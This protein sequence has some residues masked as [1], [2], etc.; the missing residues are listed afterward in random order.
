MYGYSAVGC[1]NTYT[2][3]AL[4]NTAR[5]PAAALRRLPDVGA[6][7]EADVLESCVAQWE[8][9]ASGAAKYS[10]SIRLLL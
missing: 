4:H 8:F 7:R 1:V 9:P 3:A 2:E 5:H 6:D 10:V